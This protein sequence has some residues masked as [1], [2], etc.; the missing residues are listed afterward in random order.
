MDLQQHDPDRDIIARYLAQPPRLPAE[1]RRHI[2]AGWQ[3]APVQLYAF[4]DLDPALRLTQG[5]APRGP[6]GGGGGGP[7]EGG[8]GGG[9][10]GGWEITTIERDRIQV[11]R[12]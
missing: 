6:R 7:G 12:E 8:G 2:E 11:V 1:L 5:G 10:G 9:G 3:G 4:A